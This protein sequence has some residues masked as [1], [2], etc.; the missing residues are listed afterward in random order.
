MKANGWVWINLVSVVGFLGIISFY[1]S[2][3]VSAFVSALAVNTGAQD[4]ELFDVL[5]RSFGFSLLMLYGVG[6]VLVPG[7]LLGFIRLYARRQEHTD[8]QKRLVRTSLLVLIGSLS[9][10]TL[11]LLF[12]IWAKLVG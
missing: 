4:S 5:S 11:V 8:A 6:A 2:T 3:I 10:I 9:I 1:L 7:E 12:A